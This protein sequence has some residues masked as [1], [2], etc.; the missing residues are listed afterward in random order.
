MRSCALTS[1]G[2]RGNWGTPDR[3]IGRLRTM[4]GDVALFSHGHFGAVFGVKVDRI[5]VI[6]AQHFSVAPASMGVLGL[7]FKHLYTG[8]CG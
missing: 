4:D 7:D 2:A 5:E 8:L 3:L 6:E 1:R